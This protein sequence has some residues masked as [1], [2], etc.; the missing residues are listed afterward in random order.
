MKT[1]LLQQQSSPE[2]PKKNTQKP[3]IFSLIILL[4]LIVAGILTVTTVITIRESSPS[5]TYT[6][7]APTPS[8]NI[9]AVCSFTPYK[10][11]CRYTL[12]SSIFDNKSDKNVSKNL[13]KS[14]DIYYTHLSPRKIVF[15]SFQVGVNHITNLASVDN[16]SQPSNISESVLRECQVLLKKEISG[17]N[18]SSASAENLYSLRLNV[19]EYVE[20]F[21][22]M[23][24]HQQ[25][26]LDGLEESG[27]MVIDNIRFR[28]RKMRRYTRNTRAILLNIDSIYDEICGSHS[29]HFDDYSYYSY[30]FQGLSYEYMVVC[31]SQYTFLIVLLILMLK[32]Y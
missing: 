28:V 2:F 17:L 14:D 5:T 25:A 18:A 21:N 11:L 22:R 19:E 23:E 29:F 10:R 3:C 8:H 16:I 30:Y 13:N 31:V 12:S 9:R 24:K 15:H 4:T 1:S 7:V 20:R 26:C 27:S 6:Y 32:L